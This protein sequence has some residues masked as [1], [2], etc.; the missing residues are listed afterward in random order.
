LT[1][2]QKE[3]VMAISALPPTALSAAS[4]SSSPLPSAPTPSPIDIPSPANQSKPA[5]PNAASLSPATASKS[6]STAIE[7]EPRARR[8]TLDQATGEL[9]YQVIDQRS[10]QEISQSPDEAILRMRAY[11]RQIDTSKQA[12]PVLPQAQAKG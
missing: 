12:T 11:A 1:T 5:T 9:V 7:A 3:N 2:I 10:G 8:T 6:A 4:L